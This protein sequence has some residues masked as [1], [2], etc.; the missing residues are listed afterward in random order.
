MLTSDLG[1]QIKPGVIFWF[2]NDLRLHDQLALEHA[3]EQA[4]GMGGWLLPIYVHDERLHAHTPWGFKRTGKNRDA[5]IRMALDDLSTH[6]TAL[7]STLIEADGDPTLILANLVRCLGNPLLVCEEISAPE[8]QDQVEALRRCEVKVETVWQSTLM[9]PEVLPFLPE[10]VPDRF[11]SFRQIL[12]RNGVRPTSPS[13]QIKALPDL[14][15][16]GVIET[17]RAI[18][19]VAKTEVD[20]SSLSPD[21]RSSFPWGQSSFRAGEAA[22]F[23]H[24]KQ[25]CRRGLPHS[26]KSTR[27]ALIGADYSSKWSPWLATGALSVRTAWAAI[28]DFE[29]SNGASESTYWLSFELLWRDHFRWLHRKHGRKLYAARG[30]T[31]LPLAPH[32]RVSFERWRMA[33]TGNS[34]IDAGM[35]ELATTGYISNRIRQNVA[36]FLIHDLGCDWRAGAAWFEASLIDYDVY[37]NQGNWLY[38]SGRGTDPRPNRRFNSML[39]AKTYDLDG[40][41]RALW[42]NA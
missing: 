41:Y 1:Y 23:A 6:L 8:E 9:A 27:N 10:N 17:C 25:Y 30:L 42:A 29:V 12:E 4:Q 31:D 40:T 34:F 5:W 37:S 22:A 16:S 33:K 11:T 7:G 19:P 32:N 21:H 2:R 20:L 15:A 38:L 28:C 13:G 18:L 36:S 26:Y 14:P 3:I 24:L 39:Q 35:R